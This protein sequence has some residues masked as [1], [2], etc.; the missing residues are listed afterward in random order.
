MSDKT[1]KMDHANIAQAPLPIQKL[2]QVAMESRDEVLAEL[3]LEQMCVEQYI[4]E[5]M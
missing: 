4:E 3:T 2:Y 1:Q 5:A